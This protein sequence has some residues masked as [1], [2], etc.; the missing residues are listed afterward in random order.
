MR[1]VVPDLVSGVPMSLRLPG[2]YQEDEFT[3]RFLSAFDAA[4]APVV[5]TLDGLAGYVDPWLAPADFLGWLMSWVG[6]EGDD[7]WTVPQ[8]RAI[9][10][11]AAL[12]HRRRGT[13][14]GIA[15]A[16]RLTVAEG[17]D[18]EVVDSGATSWSADLTQDLPGTT[19]PVVTV[20]VLVPGPSDAERVDVR[21]VQELLA[22]VKPAHVAHQVEVSVR[23]SGPQDTDQPEYTRYPTPEE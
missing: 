15:E 1:G 7:A 8:R 13:I 4:L 5:A 14:Q 3:E 6:V 12:L 18:V 21:R 10:A 20:R 16:V 17:C 2:V 9:V 23:P 22:S 19:P 11:G